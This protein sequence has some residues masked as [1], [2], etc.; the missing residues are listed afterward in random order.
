[1]TTVGSASNPAGVWRVTLTA[2]GSASLVD[3]TPTLPPGIGPGFYDA[4]YSP[5]L[6]LL[7]LLHRE[8]GLVASWAHPAQATLATLAPYGLLENDANAIAIRGARQP[9]AVVASVENGPLLAAEKLGVQT[10]D[11]FGFDDIACQPV[12]GDLI[13][14]DQAD[15][16]IGILA[17]SSLVIN[18][19]VSGLCGPLVA[20]PADVEWDPVAGRAVAIAAE[21]LPPCAF[22]GGTIGENH[23]VR[24]PLTASG[25]PAGNQPVLLTPLG[26]SGITGNRADI[27]LVRH[28][29]SAVTYWGYPNANA[30]TSTPTFKHEGPLAPGK[31]AALKLATAPPTAA[32][33]L[34]LGLTP[35]AAQALLPAVTGANGAVQLA[36]KLPASATPL[37]G[38]EIYMQWVADDTTTAATGDH[39]TSQT[40]VF[41]VGVK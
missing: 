15:S 3:L 16:L 27:A 11:G 6:D 13:V 12:N 35:G 32:A 14:V 33:L 21:A 1:M 23:V 2:G 30:G 25:G 28:G 29:G 20:Q 8:A 24:L 7:F 19:N 9:F 31:T 18:F 34:L 4:D 38:L 36:L 37:V 10:L 26:A 17:T 5:A 22:A 39:V 41:T 40:A